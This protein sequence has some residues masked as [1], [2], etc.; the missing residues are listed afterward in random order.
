V[1]DVISESQ[2]EHEMI[3]LLLVFWKL[4]FCLKELV[5]ES[6][7]ELLKWVAGMF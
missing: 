4:L 3:G 7:K 5:T 6:L 1:G 2:T